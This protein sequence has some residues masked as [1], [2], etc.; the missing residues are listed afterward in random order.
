MNCVETRN[1]GVNTA[2]QGGRLKIQ[3]TYAW[4]D[5]DGIKYCPETRSN[6][7]SSRFI[8]RRQCDILLSSKFSEDV[9]K[10]TCYY[11]AHDENDSSRVV[12]AQ[13]CGGLWWIQPEFVEDLV[14]RNGLT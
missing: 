3:G 12:Y 11:R 9:C 8:K 6:L 13:A 1:A 14:R 10:I 4:G 7:L 5:A 2:G